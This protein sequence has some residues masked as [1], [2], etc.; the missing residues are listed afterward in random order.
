MPHPALAAESLTE[1]EKFRQAW[2]GFGSAVALLATRDGEERHAMLATAVTSVSMDPPLLLVCVN[3]T[4]SAHAAFERRGAFTLG[5]LGTKTHHIGAHIAKSSGAARFGI[6]DWQTLPSDDP[7]LNGL[8]WLTEAQ[9]TLA[10][11]IETRHSHG[12]HSIFIARVEQTTL[13]AASDPLIFCE[14]R[15]GRFTELVS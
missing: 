1:A 5:I 4:A 14:G 2:R 15:F 7:A 10:C 3:R 6:G 9:A 8:P 13:P 11:R 12:T